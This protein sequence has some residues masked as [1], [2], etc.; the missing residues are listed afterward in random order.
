M[1]SDA[2]PMLPL[3]AQADGELV[4]HLLFTSASI[5]PDN[6]HLFVPSENAADAMRVLGDVVKQSHRSQ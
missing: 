4:G 3:I 6:G 1:R 2:E 5:E